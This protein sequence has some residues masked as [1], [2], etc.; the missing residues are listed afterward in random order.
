MGRTGK[1]FA[2]EHFGIVPD[3]VVLGKGLGGG[4]FPLA[5]ILAREELNVATEKSLG[6]Y[7]H[8]KNPAAC[9]AERRP[10]D[11][12]LAS[13]EHG[14]QLPTLGFPDPRRA[15]QAGG[16]DAPTIGMKH[17]TVHRGLMS[18]QHSD[19]ASSICREDSRGAI[20]TCGHDACAVV[21]KGSAIHP[22]LM[23]L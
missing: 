4:I 2:F 15:I 19:Q 10:R 11:V 3:I 23:P 8:E 17:G 7:T 12:A 6:H 16:N 18:L 13:F 1:F 22:H 20:H 21:A 14:Q 9:A 5:G